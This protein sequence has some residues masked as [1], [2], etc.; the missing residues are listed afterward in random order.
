M[1]HKSTL[2]LFMVCSSVHMQLAY[3]SR[4]GESGRSFFCRVLLMA[5][6]AFAGSSGLPRPAI[7]AESISVS[8][9]RN[10]QRSNFSDDEIANGFFKVAF[11]AELQFGRRQ[12]RIRKFDEPVRVFIDNRSVP[13][14]TAEVLAAVA[15]IGAHV[16]NLDL[17]ATGDR[18]AANVIVTIVRQEDFSRTLRVRFGT[19]KAKKITRSLRPVCLTGIGKDDA[20]RIRRA[21]VFLPGDVDDF[22]FS[23]CVYEELLQALGPIN[24]TSS[25]PWTMFNDNVQMGFF[26]KYDQYLLNIL[27]HP[28]LAPGMSKDEVRSLFPEI[29][30]DVRAT[31]SHLETATKTQQSSL[32]EEAISRR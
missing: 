21:E 14:R 18:A 27:Y 23:D 4:L 22:T 28:R 13:R 29:M 25:V 17:A 26:D 1:K 6:L 10:S 9:G 20:F 15:D 30:P 5:L 19:Q 31:V 7:A 16:A 3:V 2:K 32:T 12:E 24:D 11:G 8:A